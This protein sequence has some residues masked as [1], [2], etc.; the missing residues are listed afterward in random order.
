MSLTKE[1]RDNRDQLSANEAI[2]M[3]EAG[4]LVGIAVDTTAKVMRMLKRV[5]QICESKRVSFF[6]M[7]RD[8]WVDV[9]IGDGIVR[10]VSVAKRA[11]K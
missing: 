6:V 3:A 4:R 11:T 10:I 7:H 2:K 9:K 1:Q 5:E 8:G